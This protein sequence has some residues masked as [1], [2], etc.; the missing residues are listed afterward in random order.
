MSDMLCQAKV[1]DSDVPLSVHEYIL[2]LDVSEHYVP[3]MQVLE[4]KQDLADVKLGQLL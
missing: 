4:A 1:S 2:W 3:C